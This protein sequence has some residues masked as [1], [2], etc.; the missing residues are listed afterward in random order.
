MSLKILMVIMIMVIVVVVSEIA[1]AAMVVMI[2]G[3]AILENMLWTHL[4]CLFIN[5]HMYLVESAIR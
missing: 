5:Y 4:D 3:S 2:N 1:V